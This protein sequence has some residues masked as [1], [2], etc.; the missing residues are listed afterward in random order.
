[1]GDR[2]LSVISGDRTRQVTIRED[3]A[4]LVGDLTLRVARATMPGEV[5]VSNGTAIER[6]F[7]VTAGGTT[8]VFHNG[9]TF[10]L[11]V[12]SDNRTP[13]T[14]T[15]RGHQH[16]ALMAPMPATVVSIDARPGETVRR[17]AILMVLEAMK[18]ELPVRAPSDGTVIAVHCRPGDL[19]QPGVPLIE[20]Q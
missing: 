4:I 7:L 10:E 17:G 16:D 12:E 3:E 18:M 20:L 19:V 6:L 8:W 15:R 14:G 1:M 5:V 2:L 13:S 11:M 9:D